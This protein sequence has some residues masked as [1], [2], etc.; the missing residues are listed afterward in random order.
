MSTWIAEQ[1]VVFAHPNGVRTAGRIAIA[2]PVVREEDCACEIALD[3]LE[4]SVRI[5]GDDTLQA[6]LLGARFLSSRLHDFTS[7]GGRVVATQPDGEEY[8]LPLE[9]YFG[10]VRPV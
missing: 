9:A 2:A 4:R 8:D 1:P 6:L 5:Y 3:G 7:K 10:E